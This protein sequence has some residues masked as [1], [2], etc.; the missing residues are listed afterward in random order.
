VSEAWGPEQIDAELASRPE[1]AQW[2]Y[3]EERLRRELIFPSFVEAFAFMTRVAAL[4]EEQAHHP[5]WS[6]VYNRVSIALWTH[7]AGGITELDL[8]LAGAIEAVRD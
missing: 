5:D 8:R 7:D 1:L 4:A 2:T 3:R 6:N